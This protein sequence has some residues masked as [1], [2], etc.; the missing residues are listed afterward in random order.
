M[1]TT[2]LAGRPLTDI[3]RAVLH[4]IANG[5]SDARIAADMC[6]TRDTI[7]VHVRRLRAKL[8]ARDRAHA[9]RLGYAS[10]QLTL[11]G[12]HPVRPE[13]GP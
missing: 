2:T 6:R 9:V 12:I 5:R 10:G 1:T 3:E 11:D 13:A 8:G 7:K 4:G